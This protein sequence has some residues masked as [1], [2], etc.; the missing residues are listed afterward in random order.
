MKTD[1]LSVQACFVETVLMYFVFQPLMACQSELSMEAAA[2]ALN[3]G[4]WIANPIG[5]F[6]S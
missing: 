6:G 2:E 4:M 1:A 5:T 3:M